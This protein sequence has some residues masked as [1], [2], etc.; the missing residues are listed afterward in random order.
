MMRKSC[1]FLVFST[2][3][4]LA[5]AQTDVTS[6][7]IDN[8]SFENC[9]ATTDNITVGEFA[10]GEDYAS[11]GWTL[12]SGSYWSGSAVFEY[13]SAVQLNGVGTPATDPDGAA[14]KTLG[15]SVGWEGSQ[16]YQSAQSVTLPA[17]QYTLSAQAYNAGT[18]TT[19]I[20]RLAF[21]TTDGRTFQSSLRNYPVGQWATDQVEFILTTPTEGKFQIG[22]AATSNTS[23]NHAKVFFDQLSLSYIDLL[24][25]NT[26]RL[27][28]ASYAH[29]SA[30]LLI[31]GSCDMENQGWTLTNMAYQN[32][33]E[34]PT[35]YI[36]KWVSSTSNLSSSGSR[37]VQ[38]IDFLPAGA[39]VLTGVCH[40]VLQSS[41]EE[42]AGVTLSLGD[43]Q[44]AVTGAWQPVELIAQLAEPGS[45][46]VVFEVGDTR[47]NWVAFDEMTLRYGGDY[48]LFMT[49]YYEANKPSTRYDEAVAAARQVLSDDLYANVTGQERLNLVE[50]VES[51]LPDTNEA[52]LDAINKIHE[53]QKTFMAAKPAYD[54]FVGLA[55]SAEALGVNLDRVGLPEVLTAEACQQVKPVLYVAQFDAIDLYYQDDCTDLMGDFGDDGWTRSANVSDNKGE[56]WDGTA[57]S[58]YYEQSSANWGQNSWTI[59]MERNVTLAAGKYVLRTACRAAAEVA[60]TVSVS[61]SGVVQTSS[62]AAKGAQGMG[63]TLDGIASFDNSEAYAN[64]NAGYGWEWRYV[65]FTVDADN[66]E[67]TIRYEA[68]AAAVH[69]WVS[70]ADASLLRSE[71]LTG[72][73]GIH[74]DNAPEGVYTLQGVKVAKPAKG[75]YIRRGE[76]VFLK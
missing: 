53:Q 50:L 75:I 15:V 63:I 72:I 48:D 1:L 73:D 66:T 56:H 42:I 40:A 54:D 27:Q 58:T 23:S 74:A 36:E 17:G 49:D 26:E 44:V 20:S 60:G 64:D 4:A 32:N 12:F 24:A 19:M 45:L 10:G 68:S 16:I 31:N 69:Q 13:G 37:A 7:F 2:V 46:S 71:V 47:A 57:T 43:K 5:T 28:G 65:P 29:P 76:K 67:V 30:D 55:A 8:P 21:V 33:Q 9:P 11:T 35:R 34:R 62:L 70:I 38:T 51:P 25:Q 61:F 41:D 18:A 22:G 3:T 6:D 52:F 39:Y 59:T 14:G